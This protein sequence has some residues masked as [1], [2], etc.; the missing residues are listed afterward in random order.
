[1]KRIQNIVFRLTIVMLFTGCKTIH[2]K[3]PEIQQLTP[4]ILKESVV[5]QIVVPIE[6]NLK[7]YFKLA[8]QRIPKSTKGAANPCSG[9][10]FSFEFTKDSFDLKIRNNRLLSELYGSYWIKMNY[11]AGCTSLFGSETCI[12]PLVPF[13]CGIG[14]RKPS[15]KIALSTQIGLSKDYS[16]N[17]KTSID[18]LKPINPC[19]V[20]VFH[21]DA[22]GE[23]MKEVRKTID[24]Q[25]TELDK[26]LTQISFEKEA[27]SIWNELNKTIAIPYLGNLHISPKGLSMVQP[28]FENNK[29]KT[30][31]V[32]A[33]QTNINNNPQQVSN[34]SLPRLNVIQKAPKDTFDVSTNIQLNCDSLSILFTNQLK[35]EK[36]EAA[37]KTFTFE[38][39]TIEGLTANEVLIALEFSGSKNGILY[40]IGVPHFDNSTKVFSIQNLSYDLETKSSLLKTA[41]WLFDK[42]IYSELSKASTHS[43]ESEFEQIERQIERNLRQEFGDYQMFPT[44]HNINVE[45]ISISNNELFLETVISAQLQ[46]KEKLKR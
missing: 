24:K 40:L 20:T 12:T 1:M 22:T 18:E 2:T 21:F 16:L 41:K 10:R 25:C 33:C 15:V 11:C 45:Q 27:E 29:L 38:K 14:E 36:I 4:N 35:G 37:G 3:K 8:D 30:T 17:S 19:E 7:P 26:Q 43:F 39:V 31:L 42:R 5:N 34:P 44:V 13:S 6:V 23:V 28:I 46:I 9:V 32:L